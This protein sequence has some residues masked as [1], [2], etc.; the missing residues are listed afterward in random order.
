M[1]K[2]LIFSSLLAIHHEFW[3]TAV[4]LGKAEP[5]QGKWSI[6]QHVQHINKTLGGMSRYLQ[7]DRKTLVDKFGLSDHPS[8]SFEEVEAVFNK[9]FEVP[10]VSPERFNPAGAGDIQLNDEIRAGE[11][12]L[13]NMRH[14]MQQWREED[15]DR[16]NC[17][18]PAAGMFTLREML[19][20]SI[21]H[22]DHHHKAIRMMEAVR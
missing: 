1:N 14:S 22:A 12:I 19:Y 17:P 4:A 18:H 13:V 11:A 3:N 8:R 16:H 7:S 20:F 5:P 10:R 15:F 2:D 21:I 6:A 9:F